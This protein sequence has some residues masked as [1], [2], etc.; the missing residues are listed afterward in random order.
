MPIAMK[1][2]RW[3]GIYL[4]V[5]TLFGLIVGGWLRRKLETPETYIGALGHDASGRLAFAP[6]PRRIGDAGARVFEP[7]EHEQQIRQPV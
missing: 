2:L 5:S 7:C 3:L 6:D 4:L 1:W